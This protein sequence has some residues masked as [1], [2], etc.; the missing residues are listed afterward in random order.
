MADYYTNFSL[1]LKLPSEEAQEYALDL[2]RQASMANQGDELPQGFPDDLANQ[3]EE[4]QFEVEADSPAN[5][6]GIW[7]HS[8]NGGIDAVCAFIQHLLKRF[9]SQAKVKFEW[10]HDCSKPRTDAY[11]GGAAVISATEIKTMTTAGWLN[12]QDG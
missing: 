3:T 12:A 9:D 5:G 1:V 10:S 8:M 2:H 7:L 6:H 11:G 4:W